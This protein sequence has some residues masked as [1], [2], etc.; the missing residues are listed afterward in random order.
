M[1]EI[2]LPGHGKPAF[3]A[4]F[5]VNFLALIGSATDRRRAEEIVAESRCGIP[6]IALADIRKFGA[7]RLTEDLAEV[8]PY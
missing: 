2:D 8:Q 1:L 6:Q 5:T 7:Y 3:A 4:R